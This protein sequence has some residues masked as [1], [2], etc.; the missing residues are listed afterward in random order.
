MAKF[1]KADIERRLCFGD[2]LPPAE[3]PE[4]KQ[5]TEVK[6]SPGGDKI[7]ARFSGPPDLAAIKK[8]LDGVTGITLRPG[9]N[10]PV[11]QNPSDHKVEI[12]LLG[13]RHGRP[14]R[15]GRDFCE[16]TPPDRRA[17]RSGD[18]PLPGDRQ[19]GLRPE[20]PL[21]DVARGRQGS[22]RRGQRRY[23]RGALR[24]FDRDVF[25]DG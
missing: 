6:F 14:R 5:A 1:D 4:A 19:H 20:R 22:C 21:R 18:G 7:T 3:C 23:P 15:G 8:S 2:N 12:Q 25:A 17:L 9:E 10:N 13:D 11:L 24:S 16:R